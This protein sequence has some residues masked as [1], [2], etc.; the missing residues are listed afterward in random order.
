MCNNFL[1]DI[2][3]VASVLAVMVLGLSII[4]FVSWC[5]GVDQKLKFLKKEL[6]IGGDEWS[7]MTGWATTASLIYLKERVEALEI[8]A[9]GK[10]KKK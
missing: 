1:S 8:E 4:A 2:G 10:K 5:M 6:E 7:Y 9:Q 3:L